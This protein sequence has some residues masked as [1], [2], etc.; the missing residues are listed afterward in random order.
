MRIIFVR[1]ANP[2]YELDCLTELGRMQAELTASRLLSEG[3]ERIYS[4]SCGRALETASYTARLLGLDITPCDFMR[5]ISWGPIDGEKLP[6]GGEPW[7]ATRRAIANNESITRPDWRELPTY[8]KSE[9][10]GCAATVA[11][12]I[13]GWLAELGYVREGN[14][15]RVK[16]PKYKTV[17]MFCHAGSF[18]SAISHLFN[19][20]LPFIF[21]TIPIYQS[22]IV[23][24]TLT[25]VEGTLIA[26]RFAT[27]N[28]RRHLASLG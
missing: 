18:S 23:E 26:P 2:N 13:D 8:A 22:A 9:I 3:I 4:S 6:D 15:Y 11:E 16:E 5:E 14:Y 28:D 1:H 19:L 21:G 20:P 24:I 10:L 17:S 25:S 12:G 7:I 27:V